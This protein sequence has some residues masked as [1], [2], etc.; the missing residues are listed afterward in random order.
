M[1][2]SEREER[3]KIVCARVNIYTYF[4]FWN[5]EQKKEETRRDQG[6][7]ILISSSSSPPPPYEHIHTHTEYNI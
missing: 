2:A 7:I 1:R 4:F 6:Y 3:V 5:R